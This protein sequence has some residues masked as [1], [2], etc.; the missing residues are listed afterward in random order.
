[1]NCLGVRSTC[2]LNFISEKCAWVKKHKPAKVDCDSAKL[3]PHEKKPCTTLIRMHC[4]SIVYYAY[5][6]VS[7]WVAS[8]KYLV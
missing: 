3:L 1:M 5:L 4:F 6:H 2:A 8:N 7:L